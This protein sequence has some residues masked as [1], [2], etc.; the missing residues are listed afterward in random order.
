MGTETNGIINDNTKETEMET[1][2][3][4]NLNGNEDETKSK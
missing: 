2:R 1:V 3:K 4:R